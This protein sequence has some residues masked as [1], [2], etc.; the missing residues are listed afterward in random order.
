MTVTV[1]QR[2]RRTAKFPRGPGP[3][4]ESLNLLGHG[5][6]ETPGGL[7]SVMEAFKNFGRPH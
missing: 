2:K 5:L 3:R 1:T 6:Y 7:P 4:E